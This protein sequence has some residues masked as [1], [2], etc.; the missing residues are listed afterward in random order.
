MNL[1]QVFE[2]AECVAV[3]ETIPVAQPK[4]CRV[5]DRDEKRLRKGGDWVSFPAPVGFLFQL[6]SSL[7][8]ESCVKCCT[9]RV[10]VRSNV[11]KKY[12]HCS[13]C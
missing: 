2:K 7:C 13:N 1:K 6:L 5:A 3:V 4:F 10:C 11:G 9:H 12:V 8:W